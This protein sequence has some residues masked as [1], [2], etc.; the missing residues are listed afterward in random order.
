MF[1]WHSAIFS[2]ANDNRHPYFVHD[3]NGNILNNTE[4]KSRSSTFME[5]EYRGQRG[6]KN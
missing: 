6:H 5:V 2:T 4:I 1:L 3:V